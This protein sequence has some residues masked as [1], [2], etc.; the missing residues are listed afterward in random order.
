[1]KGMRREKAGQKRNVLKEKSSV[2]EVRSVGVGCGRTAQAEPEAVCCTFNQLQIFD[3]RGAT[4]GRAGFCACKLAPR[5][6]TFLLEDWL[7][8]VSLD[9]HVP[10]FLQYTTAQ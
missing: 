1:M 7:Y 9:H 2:G 4:L 8:N 10:Y 6:S 5:V 3:D